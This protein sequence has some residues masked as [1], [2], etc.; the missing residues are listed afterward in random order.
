MDKVAKD[1]R[2]LVGVVGDKDFFE[3]VFV[4]PEEKFF[5]VGVIPEAI[6][7]GKGLK[8]PKPSPFIEVY[9]DELFQDTL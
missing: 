9:R 5:A 2:S 3:G 6:Y 1:F 8:E 4:L 7:N